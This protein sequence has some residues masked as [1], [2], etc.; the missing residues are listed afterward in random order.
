MTKD[1][2]ARGAAR[3][4]LRYVSACSLVLAA[5]CVVGEEAD[6]DVDWVAD[7]LNATMPEAPVYAN[8][9]VAQRGTTWTRSHIVTTR[10]ATLDKRLSFGVNADLGQIGLARPEAYAAPL[11]LQVQQPA[12]APG[13]NIPGADLHGGGGTIIHGALCDAADVKNPYACGAHDCYDL[14]L[15]TFVTN[16]AG[17]PTMWS[18]AVTVKVAQ[19]K[20]GG[21]VVDS[22]VFTGPP[23]QGST[24]ASAMAE[25]TIAAS[26]R[27]LIVN[28]QFRNGTHFGL[29][30]AA[31]KTGAA[32]DIT[33]W[34]STKPIAAM[35]TDPMVSEYGL[36]K[37][38]LR[39]PLNNVIASNTP[40]RGAYPWVD[41]AGSNLFF[42]VVQGTAEY[43][44]GGVIK[45]HYDA[46]PASANIDQVKAYNMPKPQLGTVYMGLWSHGK[47]VGVDDQ[48]TNVDFGIARGTPLRWLRIYGSEPSWTEV[49]FSAGVQI[50]SPENAWNFLPN[51]RP[52]LPRD[53]VWKVS[54]S[55]GTDEVAFDDSLHAEA[56]IV[57]SMTAPI[58]LDRGVYFNGRGRTSDQEFTG[59]TAYD[60]PTRVQ[61]GATAVSQA[62]VNF[63]GGHVAPADQRWNVPSAGQVLGGARIEPVA[64]GG[65]AGKGLWLDGDDDR[66]EYT[67]PAQSRSF[68]RPWHVSVWIN[69][70]YGLALGERRLLAFPDGSSVHIVHQG[71][72]S[73]RR[74][75]TTLDVALP[76]ALQ[77]ST[78]KWTHFAAVSSSVSGGRTRLAIY[79]DGYKLADVT[80]DGQLLRAAQGAVT[81][82]QGSAG[83]FRGW[84]DDF[85]LIA[86]RPTA[87]EVC[88]H[89]YGT[90]V[91]VSSGPAY[92]RAGSYPSWAHREIS[93]LIPEGRPTFPR[94]VC[95][96][97]LPNAP[98]V[99]G[100]ICIDKLRRPED[101]PN[102]AACVGRELNFPE[103]PAYYDSPRP[104]ARDNPF[105]K[106]CH[107]DS[108][109]SS[110]LQ[111][112]AALAFF[113]VDSEDDARR[114]PM[115]HRPR[116][117]GHVPPWL[118]DSG[119]AADVSDPLG[120]A[121]DAYLVPAAPTG[122]DPNPPA[123]APL[124]PAAVYPVNEV[125]P[126]RPWLR[127]VARR[128]RPAITD[129]K[130]VIR[131]GTVVVH[132]ATLADP[133][134]TQYNVPAG[135]LLAG[136][137][138]EWNVRAKNAS[139]WSPPQGFVGF[140]TF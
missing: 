89:A 74:P 22:Y 48:L 4:L 17:D 87:E 126:V 118:F 43:V 119:P 36:A 103:G 104:E 6:E 24:F 83:G 86:E 66:V 33:R 59:S 81:L 19:P 140:T 50:G 79:I 56:L 113:D 31:Y 40:I 122:W 14:K 139:G 7:E 102:A 130:I 39:D 97:Q 15:M 25:P 70:R 88:N 108:H 10:S 44:E 64:K 91:G 93:G 65:V 35:H 27:L 77:L 82:G 111:A 116:M 134:A 30:Y 100:P 133:N 72:L 84:L 69:P 5:G 49:G 95:E 9:V 138:Y 136:H 20:T 11:H 62:V 109:P 8:D 54:S 47:I 85:K 12:D 92:D 18:R 67:I 13:V 28:G 42:T 132:E 2:R 26:G 135:A 124:R 90:L 117:M 34:T 112:T 51:L 57:S 115:A 3:P 53:V 68:D 16:A 37:Y 107:V 121:I 60:L 23:V 73:I 75:G 46:S 106:S 55:H 29:Q 137:T 94:Y 110:H 21:A 98:L 129:F 63:P 41:D 61:N 125:A 32:C 38:P 101:N 128:A 80:R 120:V 127:W 105:C 1:F 76:V 123:A 131:E 71:L 78:A 99:A 114:Q 58:D 52:A 96:I 45:R